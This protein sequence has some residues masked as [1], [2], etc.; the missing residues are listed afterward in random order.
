M[1]TQERIRTL[2]ADGISSRKIAAQLGVSRNTV[3]KYV[4]QQDFSPAPPKRQPASLVD[5]YA[6]I[7]EG[8]LLDDL[9]QPRK[10]RHTGR[11]VYDRLV[12]EHG[13]V[14]SYSTVQRWVKRWRQ[15]RAVAGDGFIELAWE[16]GA[17]Q[18]DFGEADA[19]IQGQRVTT[20]M[21]VVTWPYSNTR[22]AVVLPG[23]TAECVCDGLR[24]IF[25]HVGRVPARV[26]FDNAT[27]I[28]RRVKQQVTMTKLFEA[29]K[30]HYRF[31]AEFT[32]PDAG[33]EKGSVE[34]A[35]GFIRRNALVPVPHVESFQGLTTYLLT[36]CDGLLEEDHYRKNVTIRSLFDMDF[37]V[38]RD[39]PGISFD[40]CTWLDRRVDKVGNIEITGVKYYVGDAY[41]GQRIHVGM[42]AFTV[43]ARTLTGASIASHTRV[44]GRQST[45]VH[46]PEQL[47]AGLVRKPGAFVNS[48]LQDH[49][50]QPLLEVLTEADQ[51]ER[52]R[53]L[54]VL[55]RA[56]QV[57]GFETAVT[58][59][60]DLVA[61][62]RP[63]ETHEV[64][65][66]ATRTREHPA[67]TVDQFDQHQTTGVDLSV[68]D[69]FTGAAA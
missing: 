29:F 8:W 10:Q 28:G 1:P 4:N 5:V 17:A 24:T 52:R 13:F 45:T 6:H 25:E 31:T 33:N 37:E 43:E 38:M 18:A 11:R 48:P 60:T 21:L 2:D 41:A 65:M 34:N 59:M 67:N 27:G 58:V 26:V 9:R 35:V 66:V 69:K 47:V 22:Y 16:P 54:R 68:Y 46:R 57:A 56:T 32:N 7:V 36:S 49:L 42:R 62:G 55:Q 39:L 19:I 23:E 14:G 53:L 64:E 20:H 15:A 61:A 3:A 12:A 40:A 44:Y 50:P 63:L 30:L 51:P